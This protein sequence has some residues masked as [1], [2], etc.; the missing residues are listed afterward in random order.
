[1]VSL[2]KRLTLSNVKK[3]SPHESP[4]QPLALTI[5]EILERI[6]SFLSVHQRRSISSRVCRQWLAISRRLGTNPLQRLTWS[7][8]LDSQEHSRVLKALP[9]AHALL[10]SADSNRPDRGK[11]L[12]DDMLSSMRCHVEGRQLVHLHDVE[13]NGCSMYSSHIV[14]TLSLIPGLR[15]LRL[16]RTGLRTWQLFR[17]LVQMFPNLQEL[18]LQPGEDTPFPRSYDHGGQNPLEGLSDM[19]RM[20]VLAL[21]DFVFPPGTLE[22]IVSS[23]PRLTEL[24]IVRARVTSQTN[25]FEPST[26]FRHLA[27]SCP[28]LRRL[29]FSV[30]HRRYTELDLSALFDQKLL[31]LKEL[32]FMD[33]E[34]NTPRGS[35]FLSPLASRLQTWLPDE[36]E[37]TF[38]QL[39]ITLPL[40][41]LRCPNQVTWLELTGGSRSPYPMKAS[42]PVLHRFL[43]NSP[44]LQHL[45]APN[46][47]IPIEYLDING[48]M[49]KPLDYTDI[50]KAARSAKEQQAQVAPNMFS[51]VF[52]CISISSPTNVTTDNHH[53]IWACRRLR[54]L[55]VRIETHEAVLYDSRANL[56]LFGYLGRVCPD[57]EDLSIRQP[58]MNLMRYGGLCLSTRLRKLERL[59]LDCDIIQL[60]NVHDLSWVK[61]HPKK[62]L[63]TF[64]KRL[65]GKRHGKQYPL[66]QQQSEDRIVGYSQNA[67]DLT[68]VGRDADLASWTREREQEMRCMVPC[69]PSLES[70]QIQYG[71]GA[72]WQDDAKPNFRSL[73]RDALIEFRNTP[74]RAY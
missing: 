33:V 58:L 12:W 69:W 71:G 36:G 62:N 2:G 10:L 22:T 70:F 59:V 27:K 39:G 64:W 4:P 19:R 5:P 55:H 6:L 73:R 11:L 67:I 28:Q 52:P 15:T 68:N 50:R 66:P 14:P 35:T 63:I 17:E 49:K 48:M 65:I 46:L 24:R 47:A 32:S 25:I 56:V 44:H 53:R 54:T 61:R 60:S 38:R 13:V 40:P 1:M 37:Q 16:F 29:H 74:A 21:H 51:S 34:M 9:S 31:E 26:F 3:S 57:L 30:A 18:Q 8:D 72:P 45:I 7:A 42:G 41:P 23:C 43:C 20:Q